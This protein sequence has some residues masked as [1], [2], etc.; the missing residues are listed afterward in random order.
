MTYAFDYGGWLIPD[1]RCAAI[2]AREGVLVGPSANPRRPRRDG[3]HVDTL[4]KRSQ[5]LATDALARAR[6]ETT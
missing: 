3:V 4:I 2:L 6:M 5:Y 1:Y